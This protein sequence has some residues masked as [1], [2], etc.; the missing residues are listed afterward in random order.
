MTNNAAYH[1]PVM[2]Q[3]CIDALQIKPDGIY[4]DVTFGGGG[5]SRKIFEQLNEKGK[6]IAFDQDPDARKN[7]WEAPNFHFV[8]GNFAYLKN[9]LRLLGIKEV[10]GVLADLG[11]SSHQFDEE[12]RGFSIRGNAD[13]DMRMNQNS[14]LTAKQIINEYEEDDLIRIFKSYGEIPNTRKLVGEI[15]RAR[16]SQ[17]ITTTKEL[18]DVA[19]K[20]APKRKENKYLAQVFQAIRI[21]VNDEM[22]VLESFLNDCAEVLKPEGRL[23]VMSY[24]SLEDRLVKNF[25]KRGSFSGEVTKDFYGNVLKPFTEVIRKPMVANDEEIELNNRARSA[26]LRI[27]ERNG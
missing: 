20:C 5:H 12:S 3:E 15:V 16:N 19:V 17:K 8:A 26:K 9:Q 2:L 11:V 7:A 24:H 22:D 27:A 21:E 6:L 10:D 18:V 25:M 14:D 1:I 23:V 13:L 4:V